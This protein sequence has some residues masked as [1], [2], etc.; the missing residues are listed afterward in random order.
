LTDNR[1]DSVKPERERTSGSPLTAST[2]FAWLPIPLLTIAIIAARAAGLSGVYHAETLTLV[3]SVTFYTFVSLGTL[4]LIGRTFLASGEPGLLL[5][6]CGVIL[7]S[8]AGTVG[9]AVSRGDANI[10]VTI[11]NTVILLAGV[12]HLAGAIF[13][14]QP[15][16]KLAPTPLWL[17]AGG[18]LTLAMLWFVTR[19][20]LAQWLP[21]FFIPGKGGTLVR[22][23]VLI[24]AITAFALSALVLL[25]PRKGVR[26][27]FVSWYAQALLLLAVGLF[28][29]MI[30]LSLGCLVNWL[31]R[32]AQW[33]SGVYLLVGA[34]SA[35]HASD[36]P[37]LPYEKEPGERRYR[38]SVAVTV[39]LISAALRL[40]LSPTLG[41][42]NILLTFYPAVFLA[43]LYGGL[44]AGVVATG[45]AGLAVVSLFWAPWNDFFSPTAADWLS[46]VVFFLSGSLAAWISGT[47]HRSVAR[48]VKAES[49]ALLAREREA[50]SEA[51][52]ASESHYHTLF[53]GMTEGFAIHELI[54]DASG[55]PIDYRFLDVN[56]AFEHLTGLTRESVVGRTFTEVLPGED[57][58]WLERY[59][60]VALTGQPVQFENY[61]PVLDR[62]YEVLAYRSAPMQFA[63]IFMDV[64]E[65][66]KAD[67]VLK[68][69]EDRFSKAFHGNPAA[70]GITCAPEYRYVDV[71]ESWLR[72]FEYTR[73]EVIGRT[74]QELDMFPDNFAERQK[75]MKRVLDEG[76]VAN[77]EITA[78][79]RTGKVLILVASAEVIVMGGKNH[80][81]S[82]A[83]DLTDR[84][85]SEN[86]LHE[87]ERR[88][89]QRAAELA[90]VLDSVPIPVMIVHDP[91]AR[92]ITGNR[93]AHEI[94]HTPRGGEVSLSAPEE[95]RPHHFKAVKDGRELT[96]DELP[97][98]RAARGSSIKDFEFSL[99]FEN[100]E[101]RHLLGYGAPLWNDGGQPRGAVHTVV[102]ITDRKRM[103]LRL[104]S[105]LAALTRLHDLSMSTLDSEG[106]D[107]LLR[108][109]MDAAV[110]I[111]GAQRGTLQLIE[112]DSL[113]IVAHHRHERPFLEFFAR[114]ETRASVCGEVLK[115]NERVTIDDIES[116]P[117]FAGT[118]SLLVLREA[119][120]RAVQSTPIVSR[121]GSLIGVLTTQW[122]HSHTPD[123]H[124]L[125]KIDLL[126]R[127]AA[128]LIE[129]MQAHEALRKS[130][131]D[132]ELTVE[133][134]TAELQDAYK[135]L[136]KEVEERGRLEAELR[137]AQKMEALGVLS[138]GVAHDFNNLL[139]AI[140]GFTE[141]LRGSAAQGSREE[142]H[143][144]R[145]MDAA[146][147]GRDLVKQMLTFSKRTEQEKKPIALG[148]VINET[149]QLL[150]A[151]TPTTI[152]IRVD[153][154]NDVGM[155]LGDP[156]QLQQV[157]MNLCANAI[158][159]MR[160]H[161]G[162][163]S[164]GLADFV[165][166]DESSGMVPGP[167]VK[168][169]IGDTGAGIDPGIMD[170]I[171][172]PFFTTKKQ[173]DGT[174]LGLSVV[175]GIVRDSNGYITVNS[176]PG[177][178]STFHVCFPRVSGETPTEAVG[179]DEIPT[180]RERILLVDDEEMLVEMGEDILAEL[181]YEV[182]SRTSSK[183][184]LALL[185]EDPDRFDLV[186]TDQTMPDM[187]GIDLA[188]E[189]L[190]L[191]P[192]MSVILCTGFNQSVDADKAR[193]AGIKAFA[194]KPLTRKEI[195]R[196][197]KE[198]L[199]RRE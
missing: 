11:F 75:I 136:K 43:S 186:I 47:M 172:D 15:Q 190:A 41:T 157:V 54:T 57:P 170:R 23:G 160:E 84:V 137:Q 158:Y 67:D 97:A 105:D 56:P 133:E 192:L 3:L 194:M 182:T 77:H 5:L 155:I 151:T 13:S 48:A 76:R 104:A 138:G 115:E 61:A 98:Q 36:I 191:R 59:G 19:A 10:N 16:R 6:E 46:L 118:P 63:V 150:R 148:S 70:M 58:A 88:E 111:M 117:L 139:A 116:S 185:K 81:L 163:L 125:W 45:L 66:K 31:G 53:N 64:T 106:I 42:R 33:L 126:A 18:V 44:G 107:P 144:R 142:R 83:I 164:I 22:Y 80:V 130:R 60:A 49:E 109:I 146:L 101:T 110:E 114:A 50:A 20:V 141:L 35:V 119:G 175:H 165:A 129:Q 86:A 187:T 52:R 140:V 87:S 128:D 195:A 184:A 71:N 188:R 100:G 120:V 113:R 14:L 99:I 85:R 153:T 94:L 189:I 39:V 156:T 147:R 21:V 162:T 78:R 134:R 8:L 24:S 123:E 103:E 135:N 91:D 171:F 40:I 166:A 174:G 143:A 89:R 2:R 7:W 196:T 1:R 38:F 73:E 131:D 17:V 95:V 96:T 108:D 168:L 198:V 145:I 55:K 178:G 149:S 37:F 112:G 173:G 74:S 30:Q 27:A 197:V 12:C 183:D 176:E 177:K 32:T 152:A 79:T 199:N 127:Q 169:S 92:S 90:T 122:D 68:E 180:G 121:R 181:G 167:Y 28:G 25:L 9:D 72:L 4:F 34:I 93:A 69:S 62:Y 102:D 159:A 65:R 82:V 193:G 51:V 154:T 26:T 124:D 161:G 29:V 179:D 132:L